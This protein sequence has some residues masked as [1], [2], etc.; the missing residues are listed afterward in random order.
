MPGRI[1]AALAAAL[2]LGFAGGAAAKPL[3]VILAEPDGTVATDLF[4]PYAILSESG[5]VEVKVVSPTSKPVRLLPGHAWLTPQATLAALSA[6][7]PDVVIVPAM[8]DEADPARAA[9]LREQLARGGR[10]MSICNGARVLAKAGL[11]D[12]R[13]A[14]V[15]WYSRKPMAKQHPKV[16]WRHDLRWVTDGP[17]T[18]TAGISAGEPA[19]LALLGE[20]AGDEV[21]RATARR[22]SLPLPSVRHDGDGYR[23]TPRGMWTTVKNRTAVWSREDVAIPLSP[24]FDELA[25]GTALDAWSRTFRSDAWATGAP[26]TRSRHGLL[27]H[28]SRELPDR[29]DRTVALPGPDVMVRTFAAVRRAYGEETARFVALQFEHPWGAVSAWR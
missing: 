23:L 27:V 19:T 1:M 28:R 20:L 9:W 18:T 12:G 26:V 5:A 2:A 7:R 8:E 29:F 10:I 3:V 13:Q 24:G 4:A 14:T 17:V 15:H 16:K 6:R 22:L 11:L 25:F 21:M